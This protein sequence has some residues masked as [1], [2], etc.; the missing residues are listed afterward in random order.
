MTGVPQRQVRVYSDRGC[1]VVQLLGEIDNAS[2]G[3]VERDVLLSVRAA[4]GVVVDL[5]PTT[6]LDSAG[7]RCLDRLVTAFTNRGAP[8]RIAAPPDG[9]V[10][11]TLD[12]VGMLPDLLAENVDEALDEMTG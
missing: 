9:M 8:V 3:L 5:T 12:L 7:L 11:F 4:T 2:A 10:R 6:F 1:E